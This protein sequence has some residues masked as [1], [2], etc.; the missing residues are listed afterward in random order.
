MTNI[1]LATVHTALRL[2]RE[3][4]DSEAGSTPRDWEITALANIENMLAE[5]NRTPRDQWP[6]L[7]GSFNARKWHSS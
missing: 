6:A 2:A 3:R 5:V 1:E 4:C 7:M